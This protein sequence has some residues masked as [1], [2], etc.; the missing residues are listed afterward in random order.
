MKKS[1]LLAALKN[2]LRTEELSIKVYGQHM[3]EIAPRSGLSDEQISDVTHVMSNL[4]E[5]SMRHR[6]VVTALIKKLEED[7]RDDI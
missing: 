2:G 5:E 4:Q 1:K 3:T 6:D 7:P